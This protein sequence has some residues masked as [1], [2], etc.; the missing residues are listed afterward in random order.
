MLV[1][2]SATGHGVSLKAYR[3]VDMSLKVKGIRCTGRADYAIG[4]GTSGNKL[5]T[6]FVITKA[7]SLGMEQ[8]VAQTLFHLGKPLM[9]SLRSIVSNIGYRYFEKWERTCQYFKVLTFISDTHYG[10]KTPQSMGLVPTEKASNLFVLT[11]ILR[12][13]HTLVPTIVS[14]LTLCRL[15]SPQRLS[16][17]KDHRLYPLHPG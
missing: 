16:L 3:E 8:V 17:A 14:M 15:H 13:A 6:F 5:E 1:F 4:Y 2:P 9:C 12:R 11:R 10:K 7:E